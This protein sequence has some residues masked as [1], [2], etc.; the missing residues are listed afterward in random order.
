VA[1]FF[2]LSLEQ[3]ENQILF[4]QAAHTRKL[5]PFCDVSKIIERHS[6]KFGNVNWWLFLT[7][8]IGVL[9]SGEFGGTTGTGGNGAGAW[10]VVDGVAGVVG[11]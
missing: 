4:F 5:K 11:L 10:A 3:L 8:W 2:R 7:A 1:L 9:D 6:L